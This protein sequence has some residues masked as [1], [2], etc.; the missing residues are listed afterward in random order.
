MVG[1]LFVCLFVWL[2]VCLFVWLFVC[3]FVWLVGGLVVCIQRRRF[4]GH[5]TPELHWGRSFCRKKTSEGFD[6]MKYGTGPVK[7]DDDE[8]GLI[9]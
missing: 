5:W 1:W 7:D 6:P 8:V 2:V 9:D 4:L 3:L